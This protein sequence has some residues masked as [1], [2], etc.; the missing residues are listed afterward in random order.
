MNA[1]SQFSRRDWVYPAIRSEVVGVNLVL[2]V[3]LEEED[4]EE[5]EE[6]EGGDIVRCLVELSPVF[7][8]ASVHSTLQ[9]YS[10]SSKSF[11]IVFAPSVLKLDMTS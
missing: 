8:A 2:V 10:P 3:V 9:V 11:S 1:I 5:D 7:P 6:D 4:E